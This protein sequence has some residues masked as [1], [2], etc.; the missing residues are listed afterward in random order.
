MRAIGRSH[1]GT[2]L[3]VAFADRTDDKGNELTWIISA[4]E[5][6][7]YERKAYEEDPW[8]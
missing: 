8:P 2:L 4:R 6:E 1:D 7:T 5:P 3:V